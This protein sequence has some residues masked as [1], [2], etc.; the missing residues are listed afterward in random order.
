MEKMS[1]L[2]R[3]LA[4][5][6]RRIRRLRK[7]EKTTVNGFK[8]HLDLQDGG[9][10]RALSY[11]GGRERAFMSI[12]NSTVIEGMVC[13]DIGANI[14]YTTLYMLR[15]VGKAGMVYAVEPDPRNLRLLI[16]NIE[17]NN[18]TNRC[19]I[20]Q[21]AISDKNEEI[22]F[23]L[24]NKPNLSSVRKTKHSFRKT[25]VS[26]YDL[27]TFLTNRR[28]PNFIKMDVEGHE[29]KIF[30]G[31]FDYFSTNKGNT[32]I[33]VEVHPHF[34]NED[35]DFAV[36]LL[37][38]FKLGFYAKYVVSTPIPQPRLFL[39]AGYSPVAS[40]YTDGFHRGIY[41][42]IRNEDLI[43]F[44]CYEHQ[45]GNSKKIVRSFMLTRD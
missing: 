20:I 43:E 4:T 11:K 29:V 3:I 7:Y 2:A 38:Y 34:Y 9:I 25:T 1:L 30:E 31:G 42:N 40:V 22:D 26:A 18:F 8:M 35:N 33:L 37:E 21:C 10:S 24:A 23:W 6:G 16:K 32:N 41:D 5:T 45:E 19:E 44:A 27:R 14:G 12:L 17:E 15:N 13:L 39:E 36:I 28:F